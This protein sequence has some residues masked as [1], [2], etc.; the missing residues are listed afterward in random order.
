MP[1]DGRGDDVRLP[2]LGSAASGSPPWARIIAFQASIAEPSAQLVG[3]VDVVAPGAGEHLAGQGEGQL[4]HVGGTAAGQ[5]L[6]GLLD[7]DRVARGQ[8]ERGGHVG[9]QRD[10]VHAGVGAER[11]HRLGE[12]AGRVERP[13]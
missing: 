5:H 3:R 10:G 6:D 9:E 1:P 7:L 2:R 4:D 12:L 13:S 8:P 11:H